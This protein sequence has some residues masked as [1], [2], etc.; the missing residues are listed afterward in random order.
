MLYSNTVLLYYSETWTIKSQKN[1]NYM[2]INLNDDSHIHMT[3]H[4]KLLVR[5]ESTNHTHYDVPVNLF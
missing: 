3:H 1:M 2:I 5:V 4:K